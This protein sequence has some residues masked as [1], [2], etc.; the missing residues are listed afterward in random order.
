MGCTG[1]DA[2]SGLTGPV[3]KGAG[4]EATRGWD[5]VTGLGTPDLEAL[6]VAA[7]IWDLLGKGR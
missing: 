2:H 3:V 6:V 5:P 1:L 4:W 7:D